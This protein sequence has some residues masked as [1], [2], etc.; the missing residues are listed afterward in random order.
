MGGVRCETARRRLAQLGSYAPTVDVA[1]LPN[2]VAISCCYY[3]PSP[4][5]SC[6]NSM[7]DSIQRPRDVPFFASQMLG[8]LP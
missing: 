8:Q 1:G 7:Q 5:R 2:T 6:A 4:R 3:I